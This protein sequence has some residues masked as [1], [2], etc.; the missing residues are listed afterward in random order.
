MG[1]A[2]LKQNRGSK[3]TEFSS[4]WTRGCFY[5]LLFAPPPAPLLN[6]F[7]M[8]LKVF[9]IFY[10]KRDQEGISDVIGV[11]VLE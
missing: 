2:Y 1:G 5:L 4:S 9:P 6:I 7:E 10:L 11:A 8:F 3:G